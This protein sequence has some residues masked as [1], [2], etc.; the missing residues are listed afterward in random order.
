ME[1]IWTSYK[2]KTKPMH[3]M[4]LFTAA[5]CMSVHWPNI[6]RTL[7]SRAEALMSSAVTRIQAEHAVSRALAQNGYPGTFINCHFH[8][9]H[10]PTSPSLPH[11][12]HLYYH[13]EHQRDLSGHYIDES[14]PPWHYTTFRPTN[15]LWQL[16]LRPKDPVPQQERP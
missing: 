10:S 3:N 6:I 14:C 15:T 5:L 12:H 1:D 8:T 13:T 7:Y 4:H 16:L 2:L 9:L 11:C